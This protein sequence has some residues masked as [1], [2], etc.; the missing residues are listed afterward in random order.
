MKNNNTNTDIPILSIEDIVQIDITVKE[1]DIS[2]IKESFAQIDTT[3]VYKSLLL[4]AFIMD[5]DP[6]EVVMKN[7]GKK[8]KLSPNVFIA[9]YMWFTIVYEQLGITA[10]EVSKKCGFNQPL[11][12]KGIKV[13]AEKK[14]KSCVLNTK[15]HTILSILKKN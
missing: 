13:F 5:V 4:S 14:N 1:S 7:A 11:V 8:S 15:Y 12:E 2:F 3:F 9:R 6:N 10:R